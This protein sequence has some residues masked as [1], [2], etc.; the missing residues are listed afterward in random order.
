MHNES[1]TDK[2]LLMINKLLL[3]LIVLII[4]L[5]LLYVLLGSFLDPNVLLS[6]GISLDPSDWTLEGYK[7]V[8]QDSR[9]IRSFFN[10]ILYAAGFTICT[11]VLTVFA[12]YPLS[13]DDFK[14]RN[15]FMIFFLITM[16]FNG[17]LIPTY[18][19]VKNLGLLNTIC[20]IILPGSIGVWNIILVRT[21]FR[22][23]PKEL[24]QAAKIDGASEVQ[25]FFKIVLPLSKPVIFVIA[26]YAFV[27]QWNAYFEAMI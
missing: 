21:F 11:V 6:K 26:L 2:F 5:P 12:A 20:A 10:S 4:L 18:L 3:I 7:R 16:F 9:I 1:K 14:G 15:V 19:L 13:I 24:K 23:L 8:F 27:G 25:V 17:G 22:G